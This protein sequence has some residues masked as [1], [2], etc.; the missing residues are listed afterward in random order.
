MGLV[1]L[2]NFRRERALQQRVKRNVME[3]CLC[4][5]WLDGKLVNGLIPAMVAEIIDSMMAVSCLIHQQ[6][7]CDHLVQ[8]FDKKGRGVNVYNLLWT[9]SR[10]PY[11][12][13]PRRQIFTSPQRS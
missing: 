5:S 1:Q 3:Y 9:A 7:V 4:Y 11:P 6:T 8:C 10:R 13:P 2:N 12:T